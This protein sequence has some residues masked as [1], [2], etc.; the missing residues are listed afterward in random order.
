MGENNN[1][2]TLREAI[3]Q[4][5]AAENNNPAFMPQ[6]PE[7]GAGVPS[8]EAPQ[9]ADTAAAPAP[10]AAMQ[11]QIPF[12]TGVQEGAAPS[13]TA[14]VPTEQ[15]LQAAN[16]APAA[17]Q[18][19]QM[20]QI[21]MAQMQQL[22]AQNAQLQQAL[23]QA[24]GT[25][26]EQSRAAEG[27]MD[28]AMTQPTVTVPVL[29]F[30]ELQYDDD[31]TRAKKTADWQAALTAS[32]RDSVEKQYAD[33][34]APIIAEYQAKIRETEA[35]RAKDQ[36]YGDPRFAD[37]RDRDAQIEHIL[38][39]V[40]E[41]G[42]LSPDKRYLLGGMIAR[43]MAYQ[44]QPTAEDLV[45]QVQANP[46]AL[47]MLDTER[48]RTIADRNGQIPTILPSSGMSSAN[49]IP[50]EIPKDMNDMRERIAAAMRRG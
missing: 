37:F 1:N 33:Q 10:D 2:L 12:D 39:T 20:F 19:S 6:I 31:A 28:S 49:A 38:S 45:R 44:S 22:Q 7:T 47:R 21:M 15:P 25:V 18:T 24:Q 26:Q 41:L 17:D 16:P 8:G 11:T 14:A 27:A 40:P 34:I 32:I 3:E 29:D 4:G 23:S 48:A 50:D 5:F 46:D 13:E 9:A 43:G 36:L 42:G 30:N 35:A